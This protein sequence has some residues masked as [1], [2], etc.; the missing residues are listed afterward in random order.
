M[1][2]IIKYVK[3]I[4][5]LG[6]VLNTSCSDFGDINDNPNSPTTPQAAE[7]VSNTIYQLGNQTAQY[8][9][10]YNAALMQYHG[11]PDFNY[12]DQYRIEAN[13]AVWTGNYSLLGGLN[14]VLNNSKTNPSMKAVTKILKAIIG[15]ELTDLYGPVPFFEAGNKYNLTPKYNQQQDI[16]TN[17][18]GVL[19]LLKQAVQTLS[20]SSSAISGDI[21]FNGE[22]AQWIKFANVLRLKYLMRI[23]NVYPSAGTKIKAIV[24]SGQIFSSNTD[25]AV[26]PYLSE[27]NN[28][29]L[30]TAR[31]G[32]FGLYKITTTMLDLLQ[33][34]N[35]PRIA[36]FYT[37]ND[38][39][40]YLPITPGSD[41]RTTSFT[42]LSK[43][44]RAPNILNMVYATYFEQ[45]F[46]LAEAALNNFIDASTAKKHYDNATKAAFAFRGVEMPTDYLTTSS[47]GA[48]NGTLE[49][50]ITQKYIANCMVG[51][52]AWFDYRRTGFPKLTPALNN[53]N[54]NLIPVRF[55]YPS[56]EI[57]TNEIN[58]TEALSWLTAGNDYNS[59]SWWD[60][61]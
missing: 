19:D 14:D 46:I 61:K 58:N 6:L 60:K 4:L 7:I 27:P 39:G 3:T 25:N 35:D 15:A 10:E 48:W 21:M 12:I 50:L 40:N 17:T 8:G 37:P 11:K 56:E 34:K 9:F 41:D 26:L 23:S 47:K 59:K 1:K 32:D 20:T 36:F 55:Q 53:I 31:D 24:D 5:L 13:N 43:N 38:K 42:G 33:S 51:Y 22:K 2:T 16:Y 30:S 44:M 54:S 18:N 57:F 45:E 28:W 29:F 52:E 49:N